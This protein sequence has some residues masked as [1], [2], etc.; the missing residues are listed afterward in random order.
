MSTTTCS[1]ARSSDD[2]RSRRTLTFTRITIA[3]ITTNAHKA[4]RTKAP[5]MRTTN[6]AAITMA[7]TLATW[8]AVRSEAAMPGCVHTR[9]RMRASSSRPPAT[10]SAS[11]RA[12]SYSGLPTAPSTVDSGMPRSASR[13]AIARLISPCRSSPS[14]SSSRPTVS[15]AC[16]SAIDDHGTG[17]GLGDSVNCDPGCDRTERRRRRIEVC[18]RVAASVRS[19]R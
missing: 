17:L 2:R 9:R 6:G 10:S 1:V 14:I 12:I 7:A 15:N 19:D 11:T 5:P 16:G 18:R 3:R 13:S 4:G 8:V